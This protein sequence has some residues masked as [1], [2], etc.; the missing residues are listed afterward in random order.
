V[1][2]VRR[3]LGLRLAFLRIVQGCVKAC[4]APLSRHRWWGSALSRKNRSL[5]TLWLSRCSESPLASKARGPLKRRVS[6]CS[7]SS[8]HALVSDPSTDGV[9]R[10]V[11]LGIGRNS[12][13]SV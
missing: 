12:R 13:L 1:W 6:T 3:T 11:Q 4:R 9:A 5:M 10:V 2:P 8:G 7:S